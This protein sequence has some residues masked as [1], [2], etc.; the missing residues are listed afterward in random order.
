MSTL[1]DHPRTIYLREADP[2]PNPDGWL[3]G[4]FDPTNEVERFRVVLVC[5]WSS[6]RCQRGGQPGAGV[7]GRAG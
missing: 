1:L 6:R 4:L 5:S 2:L 7:G 3:S